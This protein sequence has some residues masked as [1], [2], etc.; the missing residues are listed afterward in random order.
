MFWLVIIHLAF[1]LSVLLTAVIDRFA[2]AQHP[3]H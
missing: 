1:A 2:F 3:Q